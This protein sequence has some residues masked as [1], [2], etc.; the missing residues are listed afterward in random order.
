MDQERS[1]LAVALLDVV[2]IPARARL[3]RLLLGVVPRH[4]HRQRA[5]G[6]LFLVDGRASR[7]A[8]PLMCRH[9]LDATGAFGGWRTTWSH[10]R[11]RVERSR[12]SKNPAGGLPCL[13][14]RLLRLVLYHR[15]SVLMLR[16]LLSLL[17]WTSR[18]PTA[19]RDS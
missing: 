14:P 19:G 9:A 13:A 16:G 15:G 18:T 11:A 10:A 4:L 8:L 7:R 17:S 3:A 5:P 12:K 2:G 6:R 1:L